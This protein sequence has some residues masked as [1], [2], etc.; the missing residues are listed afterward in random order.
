LGPS[1]LL[2]REGEGGVLGLD[3]LVVTTAEP[4]RAL[5][6]YGAKLGLDLRLDR[7]N[8]AWGVR[9][10]FF[11]C[12]RAVLETVCPMNSDDRP[13]GDRLSGLA[14]RVGSA[15]DAHGRLTQAG[16]SLSEVRAGRKP[17]TQVFTLRDGLPAAPCL[18]IEQGRPVY[19]TGSE[20]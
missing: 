15:K 18:L 2:E 4:E 6:L 20:D 16:F 13:A 10:Q 14:W 11:R 17:G 9:Q 1:P 12:G 7:T 8:P 3:H 19:G 5:G